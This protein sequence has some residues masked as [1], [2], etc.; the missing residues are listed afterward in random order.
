MKNPTIE[1]VTTAIKTLNPLYVNDIL[2]AVL[3]RLHQENETLIRRDIEGYVWDI[4]C[5]NP[6]GE[7]YPERIL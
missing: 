3:M 2:D 1:Q 5:I 7:L 6:H 4:K